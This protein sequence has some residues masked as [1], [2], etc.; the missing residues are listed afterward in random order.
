MQATSTPNR[1]FDALIDAAI[2]IGN[3]L[4]RYIVVH[5]AVFK[6]LLRNVIPIPGIFKPINFQQHF[7]SLSFIGEE[8]RGVL[9][10]VRGSPLCENEFAITLLAYGSAFQD[11]LNGLREM[12]GNLFQK[13]DRTIDYNKAQYNHDFEE[14][15][16]LVARYQALGIRLN[17]YF[18]E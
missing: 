16:R 1:D 4:N 17:S 8:A 6:T 9:Q 13:A 15:Q 11:A 5:D 3:L 12:C 10:R 7:E 2:E 18:G 14:Y